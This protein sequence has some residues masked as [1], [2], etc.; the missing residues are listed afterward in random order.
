MQTSLN[1]A[2]ATFAAGC[3]WGTERFYKR[4][5]G[6]PQLS[7]QIIAKEVQ[8]GSSDVAADEIKIKESM[9]KKLA[10]SS[11]ATTSPIVFYRVGY[12]CGAMDSNPPRSTNPGYK[13]VCKGD[14]GC[15]EV[16]QMV[17]V[18]SSSSVSYDDLVYHFFKIHE[19]T[20]LNR[21]HGDIGT[22]YRSSILV[23]TAEQELI[24][25]RIIKELE[26]G[27]PQKG[28]GEITA[29]V[30]KKTAASLSF[31]E[32]RN[33][34]DP[35]ASYLSE[36]EI[37]DNKARFDKAFKGLPIV[38]TIE[39]ATLFFDAEA[40]HQ[41]YLDENPDGYCSHRKYW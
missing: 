22:Q 3:F 4:A 30:A 14:T 12:M 40:Y 35:S 11:S 37:A 18:P 24:A 25:R 13:A 2:T 33:P 1:L 31:S 8:Q 34:A 7:K 26:T 27:K 21:Q 41:E 23:H 9:Q 17:Y 16:L 5:F 32:A 10:S 15:A 28:G 20:T 38:T 36:A 39:P 6:A 19:P 29:T